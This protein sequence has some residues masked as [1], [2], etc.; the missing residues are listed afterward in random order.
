MIKIFIKLW[1][2][3]LA[4]LAEKAIALSVTHCG[5]VLSDKSFL[6]CHVRIMTVPDHTH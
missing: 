5:G 4:I 6:A 3:G 1:L 2:E